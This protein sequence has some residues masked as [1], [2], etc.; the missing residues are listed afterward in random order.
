MEPIDL[1]L[2]SVVALITGIVGQLTSK[3]VKGGWIVNFGSAFMGAFVGV[4]LARAFDLLAV[5]SIRYEKIDF[6]LIWALIGSVLFVALVG[7][8]LRSGRR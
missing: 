1:V 4:H 2:I 6:P 5:F 7:M 3:Y 8:F